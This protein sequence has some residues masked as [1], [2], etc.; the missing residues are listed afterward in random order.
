M[1]SDLRALL[2]NNRVGDEIISHLE[3]NSVRCRTLEQFPHWVDDIKEVKTVLL[4]GTGFESSREQQT[5]IRSAW[6]DA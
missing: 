1:D 2:R 4:A 5:N 6:T 3:G